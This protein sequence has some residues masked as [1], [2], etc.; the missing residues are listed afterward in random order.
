LL[1]HQQ[2]ILGLTRE[3]RLK[4][5]LTLMNKLSNTFTEKMAFRGFSWIPVVE[6]YAQCGD[7][8]SAGSLARQIVANFSGG[9]LDEYQMANKDKGLERLNQIARKYRFSLH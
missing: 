2:V 3:K 9:K 4:E 6:L 7:N 8:K 1:A 5:A